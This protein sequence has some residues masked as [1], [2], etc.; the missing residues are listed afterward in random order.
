VV[1]PQPRAGAG[2]PQ[3]GDSKI[4]SSRRHGQPRLRDPAGRTA[5]NPHQA[6]PATL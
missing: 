2:L 5:C 4:R 3:T 1:Q 6:R